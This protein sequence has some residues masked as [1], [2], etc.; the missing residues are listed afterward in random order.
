MWKVFIFVHYLFKDVHGNHLHLVLHFRIPN[1]ESYF[2]IS[3]FYML[4]PLMQEVQKVEGNK[5]K[6]KLWTNITVQFTNIQKGQINIL[7]SGWIWRVK[8]DLLQNGSKEVLHCFVL[9]N[10]KEWNHNFIYKHNITCHYEDMIIKY[11]R[12]YSEIIEW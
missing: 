6:I 1:Q 7:S 5:E 10:E 2:R 8:V 4:Q 3:L 11:L 12:D 9:F